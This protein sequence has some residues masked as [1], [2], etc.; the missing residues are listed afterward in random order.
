VGKKHK[1]HIIPRYE[2]GSNDSSNL[3][4]LTPT[5]HA[6]WHFAEWQRKGRDDDRIAWR[7]L[8]GLISTSEARD[9]AMR[10]GSKR[11]AKIKV[12]NNPNWH[13][14]LQLAANNRLRWLRENDK[15]W[16]DAERARLLNLGLEH[17][18]KGGEAGLGKRWWYN[19]KT[20]E[21]TR[22]F[23]QPGL[24]WKNCKAPLSE[25]VKEKH[26][27]NQTGNVFW[28]DGNISTRSKKCPGDGW[29]RGRLPHKACRSISGKR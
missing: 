21:M 29:V 15:H 22:S 13:E 26:R 3:V 11:A 8:T 27:L 16:R 23:D 17:G 28:N 20:G 18:H 19:D 9:E 10:L 12:E 14:E 24:D 1:H 2:G 5:Q 4:E 25:T 6:M 7:G